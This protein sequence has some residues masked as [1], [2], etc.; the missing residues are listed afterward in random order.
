[1]L[2]NQQHLLKHGMNSM[3]QIKPVQ[4]TRNYRSDKFS[5]SCGYCDKRHRSEATALSCLKALRAVDPIPRH[6]N[7]EK[8]DRNLA[9]TI[10][11]INGDSSH[12]IGS[13]YN[14]SSDRVRQIV[15]R[16]L[17]NVRQH[18]NVKPV[19]RLALRA[20]KS[21]WINLVK[22]WSDSRANS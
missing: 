12:V 6:T 21:Y 13:S 17:N 10:S 5:W 20:N 14:I 3:Q 1:M 16:T 18:H 2:N 9:M 4:F 7:I 11:F 8:P 19:S 15:R 22:E